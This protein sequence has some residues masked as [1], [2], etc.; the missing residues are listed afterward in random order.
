[1][2]TGTR[3]VRAFRVLHDAPMHFL[4][5]GGPPSERNVKEK[6]VTM[7]SRA[8]SHNADSIEHIGHLDLDEVTQIQTQVATEKLRKHSLAG[9]FL[10]EPATVLSV[11]I[12][13][14]SP[15]I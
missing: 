9:V 4:S 14:C 1:M 3:L 8:I 15:S 13:D 11:E 10:G 6:R 5:A 7:K 2:R 12:W